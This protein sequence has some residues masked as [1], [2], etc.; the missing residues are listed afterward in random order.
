[1]NGAPA[2]ETRL[3]TCPQSHEAP[4]YYF[5]Y[6]DLVRPGDIQTVLG[7]QQVQ[8][9]SLLGN[10]SEEHSRLRYAPDKWSIRQVLGHLNDCERLFAFRAFWF[11][12]GF[13][14]ALP[15]FDQ[16]TAARHDSAHARSWSSLVGEFREI[17]A[18]TMS[19]FQHLPDEA[20]SRRGVA[21]GCEFT[22]RSLA[23]IIAGHATHHESLL[24]QR[25]LPLIR[26]QP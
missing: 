18:S 20:W 12:R 3:H 2:G 23:Y 1:M 24:R 14:A 5:K 13:D 6:I 10:I 4:E 9:L 17:R 22:V 11:A 16:E 8:M 15:A 7:T 19:L 21:S 25:Y 26:R